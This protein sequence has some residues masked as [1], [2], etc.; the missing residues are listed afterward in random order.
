MS[1]E[2]VD[3]P[4]ITASIKLLLEVGQLIVNQQAE[5]LNLG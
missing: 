3:S 5:V 4:E 1:K 2:T